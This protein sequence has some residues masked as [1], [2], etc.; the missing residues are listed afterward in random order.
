VNVAQ[1]LL[2]L[3]PGLSVTVVILVGWLFLASLSMAILS[4]RV[5]PMF[6]IVRQ[7]AEFLLMTIPHAALI[8]IAGALVLAPFTQVAGA[9]FS[10]YPCIHTAAA[11]L[12]LLVVSVR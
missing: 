8:G 5:I 11:V 9:W 6:N 3:L 2:A 4:F 7:P 10:W 1:K 12:A